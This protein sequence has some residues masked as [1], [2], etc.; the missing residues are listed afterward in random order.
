M[1]EATSWTKVRGPA[2]AVFCERKDHEII[3]SGWQVSGMCGGESISV[4]DTCT[5]DIKKTLMRHAKDVYW[6]KWSTKHEVEEL[7]KG[8]WFKPFKA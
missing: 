3:V 2:G 6:R 8:V 4:E 5:E 1:W 7:K